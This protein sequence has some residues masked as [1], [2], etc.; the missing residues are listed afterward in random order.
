MEEIEGEE[1][2]K[3]T[4]YS[5]LLMPGLGLHNL[6]YTANEEGRITLNQVW[7]VYDKDKEEWAFDIKKNR[8]SLKAS[9]S[10]ELMSVDAMYKTNELLLTD[11][12]D[13]GTSVL[14]V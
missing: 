1:K 6:W 13:S 7:A 10:D 3:N 9:S 4:G 14:S 2:A 11:N 12:N 5:M 8:F